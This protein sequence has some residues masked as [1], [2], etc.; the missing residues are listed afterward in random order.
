MSN[1]PCDVVDAEEIL[2][3]VTPPLDGEGQA[4]KTP[5]PE[6]KEKKLWKFIKNIQTFE[7]IHFKDGPPFQFPA[8]LFVT[9]DEA[10]AA[11]LLEVADRHH[12]LT[13]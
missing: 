8:S 10:L 12:I 4:E 11:R 13:G 2:A 6:V 3:A 9:A 5:A 7:V 1:R